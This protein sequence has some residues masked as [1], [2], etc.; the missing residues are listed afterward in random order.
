MGIS[1]MKALERVTVAISDWTNDKL[2]YKADKTWVTQEI[3][4]KAD[5][6]WVTEQIQ[7]TLDATWEGSY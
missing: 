2:E 1:I 7:K 5:K 4:N 6:T 3:Q